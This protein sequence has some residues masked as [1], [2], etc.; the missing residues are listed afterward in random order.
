LSVLP[1]PSGLAEHT[2]IY[3]EH[4]SNFKLTS[5]PVL[6]FPN[7]IVLLTPKE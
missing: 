2:Y 1:L 4:I 7:L 6:E 5:F 3:A